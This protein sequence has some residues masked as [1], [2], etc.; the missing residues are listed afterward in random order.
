MTVDWQ[1]PD[2]LVPIEELDEIPSPKTLGYKVLDDPYVDITGFEYVRGD[3]AVITGLLQKAIF[4]VI[5][6]N[7][8]PPEKARAE[9]EEQFSMLTEEA[10]ETILRGLE[11]EGTRE[12]VSNFVNQ[13][14]TDCVDGK[15]PVILTC[16][17]PSVKA[18]EDIEEEY[19]QP[20]A[21]ARAGHF[22]NRFFDDVT[23]QEGDDVYYVYT[24]TTGYNHSGRKLPE[25]TKYVGM[26][27]GM[28][29]PQAQVQCT[30]CGEKWTENDFGKRIQNTSECPE[31][32]WSREDTVGLDDPFNIDGCFAEWNKIADK[33]IKSKT[34]K[35]LK[36]LGW[37]DITDSM[38]EQ[39]SLMAF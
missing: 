34:R 10:Q 12:Q 30:E 23:I 18:V 28:E 8:L 20:T 27:E 7:P 32:V 26:V 25:D 38:G 5:L 31:C 13:L 6:Q 17:G 9:V 39:D 36:H 37:E 22:T 16:R 21:A 4:D 14:Y 33:A 19:K 11:G 35:V 2:N 24:K 1:D 15:Y 29:P 3:S